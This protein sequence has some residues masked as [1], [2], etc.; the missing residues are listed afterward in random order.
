MCVSCDFALY[1]NPL[2]FPPHCHHSL[3]TNSLHCKKHLHTLHNLLTLRLFRFRRHPG[4]WIKYEFVPDARVKSYPWFRKVV[5]WI[6][7]LV[8]LLAQRRTSTQ[9][10]L[11]HQRN[12]FNSSNHN[13]LRKG[14]FP[15]PLQI[16]FSPNFTNSHHHLHIPLGLPGCP[17]GHRYPLHHHIWL[18]PP[19]LLPIRWH[20][21]IMSISITDR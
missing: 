14:Q 8:I 2:S 1:F 12:N 13:N 19:P 3:F 21:I 16:L 20:P 17:H 10:R 5:S 18:L 7:V 6:W 9:T 15:L 4:G 11:R